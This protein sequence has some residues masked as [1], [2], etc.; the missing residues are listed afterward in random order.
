APT[1]RRNGAWTKHTIDAKMIDVHR[2]AVGDMDKNGTM[3]I[4]VSEQ[5]QA[6]L[7]RVTVYYNNGNGVLTPETIS[8]SEGHNTWVGDITGTGKLEIFNSGHGYFLNAHPLQ[9]FINPY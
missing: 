6:P 5:D 2:I 9:I 8:N 7:R 3:D 1:D 4:I